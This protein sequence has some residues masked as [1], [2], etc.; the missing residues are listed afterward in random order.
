MRAQASGARETLR[1][2]LERRLLAI[3]FPAGVAPSLD[4][5]DRPARSRLP[6]RLLAPL[7]LLTARVARAR[8]ARVQRRAPQ[9]RPAV[10]VIGN[11]V[12][13][14]TGKTPAAIAVARTLAGRGWR[15]AALAGGYRGT[16]SDA[17]PVGPG[18]DAAEHGDE[19]VLLAR[20]TGVPVAAG[21]RRGE[22][23][24]LLEARE[25]A[26]EIVVCD[27][28]LQHP[29]LPRTLE[30]AVFDARGAGNGRLLPAGP[31]REPLAH[32]ASMDALLLN[33]DAPAPLQGPRCFRFRIEPT[34]FRAL[35]D[36][37]RLDPR[38]FAALAAGRPLA[39]LAGI[40]QPTRFFAT[41][42]ALGLSPTEHPLPDHALIGPATLA[43]ITA[44][45]IVMT[46]KDA[47]KCAAIADDRCWTLEVS[48]RIE[49][50]FYDWIEERLR[51]QPIA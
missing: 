9:D 17:R 6:E 38:A 34:A 13:G 10:V 43:A 16:R 20:A 35:H 40:A 15:V 31:L 28:G 33:G 12:V 49:P 2:A 47:V 50:A 21:R 22:A 18:D 1:G 19:A 51:G 4:A 42:R 37:R 48:A 23:L 24:A 26:P 5:N 8:R 45:L 46:S 39:A 25:P 30:V 44:P 27:D 14:G 11:L 29:G 32:A 41:L 7:S 36:G 3:W